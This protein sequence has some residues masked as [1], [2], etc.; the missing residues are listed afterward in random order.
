MENALFTIGDQLKAIDCK[1]LPR[2]HYV[3][4]VQPLRGDLNKTR[5]TA[6][7]YAKHT[8]DQQHCVHN[9]M[10][11]WY[12]FLPYQSV[13]WLDLF[14]PTLSDG[15]NYLPVD[16]NNHHNKSFLKLQRLV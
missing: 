13:T 15:E 12:S 9:W 10:A 11:G 8:K 4:L 16:L 14:R 1:Q 7:L 3:R 2:H 5:K 6:T